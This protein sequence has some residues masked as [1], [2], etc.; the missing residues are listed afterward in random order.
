[1]ATNQRAGI[2]AKYAKEFGPIL[3]SPFS[4][5][6][7]VAPAGSAGSWGFSA[8]PT[9]PTLP[10]LPSLSSLSSLPSLPSLPAISTVT[11]MSISSSGGYAL[12]FFFYFFLYGLVLFLMLILIHYAVYPMFQFVPGGKGIIPITTTTDYSMYWNAG[13]QPIT[14]APDR[15]I[16]ADSLIN[17]KFEN[18]YSVSIDICLTDLTGKSGLDRLIF[19]SSTSPFDPTTSLQSGAVANGIASQFSNKSTG[20]SM[21]CYVDDSTN[22][23]IVTYFLNA[24]DGST[25]QRSSFPIQ[26]IPLYTPFR[27]MIA[28]DTNIF[29][30]YYNGLQVSQTSVGGTSPQNPGKSQIFYANTR[31]GKCGYVQTLMLWSRAVHQEELAGVKVA[32]TPISKFAMPKFTPGSGPDTCGNSML[33]DLTS[34][35][36][37]SPSPTPVPSA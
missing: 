12:Q 10:S 8:L 33:T 7:A 16:L 21:I 28:Y 15:S 4:P 35:W 23:V 31:T 20:V 32:L 26:N 37:N 36:A 6:T 25:V 30:V 14:P 29:T 1:M 11:G 2:I 17:Y 19:Y 22:D 27:I 18:Q 9:L 24:G 5:S 34:I 3:Q 13:M